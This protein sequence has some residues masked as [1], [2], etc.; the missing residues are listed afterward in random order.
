[1][2]Q[3]A[4]AGGVTKPILYRHFGD[5]DGLVA[6]IGG[7]FAEELT[8]NLAASLTARAGPREVLDATVDSFVSFIERDPDLYRFL[9]QQAT[10]RPEGTE[11]VAGLI[12]TI[13]RRVASVLADG[14]RA[15]GRDPAAADPWARGIVG[16]VRQSADWWLDEQ[17]MSREQL[18]QHL[19]DLLWTGLSQS[20]EPKL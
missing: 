5:R 18:V 20:P 16:M 8:T 14:L 4:T 12:E 11:A 19:T 3:M 2:E 9:V 7:Q 15:Q 13:S 10:S 1:M 6:T 17:S